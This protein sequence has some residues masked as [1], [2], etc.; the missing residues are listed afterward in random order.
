M[1][2]VS[3]FGADYV[4]L[5]HAPFDFR[6]ADI[7]FSGKAGVIQLRKGRVSL[8]MIGKGAIRYAGD[9]LA[10]EKENA[11]TKTFSQ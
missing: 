3:E 11:V 7:A 10:N 2:I 9:N 4:L 1:K 8:T 6:D 5:S